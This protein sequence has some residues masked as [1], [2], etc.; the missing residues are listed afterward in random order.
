M[1][2]YQQKTTTGVNPTVGI[3]VWLYRTHFLSICGG[4]LSKKFRNSSRQSQV[5]HFVR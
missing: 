5:E 1:I 3:Y 2:A 4:L